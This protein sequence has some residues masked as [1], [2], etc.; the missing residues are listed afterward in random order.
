MRRKRTPTPLTCA[1][2]GTLFYQLWVNED[3][4]ARS[5][6]AASQA[7]IQ[8][9]QLTVSA[10]SEETV[11]EHNAA[12]QAI[13]GKALTIWH[14][15]WNLSNP[16]PQS[17]TFNLGGTHNV[18]GLKYLPRQIGSNGTITSYI[19]YVSLDGV[20]YTQAAAGAWANDATEK[21]AVFTAT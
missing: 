20:N 11:S 17:I 15:K 5:N 3:V 4:G 19:I 2:R 13:D 12:S 7:V 8:Q 16:L 14:T 9:S 21:T 10:T 18:N 1:G 6:T